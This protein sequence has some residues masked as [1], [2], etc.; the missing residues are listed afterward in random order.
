MAVENNVGGFLAV[1]TVENRNKRA[2][3]PMDLQTCNL[4][5]S[6]IVFKNNTNVT[7]S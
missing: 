2:K 5:V 1:I 3:I 7:K 6:L 4:W